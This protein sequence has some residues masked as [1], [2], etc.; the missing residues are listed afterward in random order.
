M[1][2]EG[3][4]A[5]FRCVLRWAEQY[6]KLRVLADIVTPAD[7]YKN[8]DFGSDGVGMLRLDDLLVIGQKREAMLD[9]LIGMF[10]SGFVNVFGSLH[11][12]MRHVWPVFYL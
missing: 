12:V 8:M 1:V 10:M 7:S 6:K 9:Y 4:N 3:V 11:P 5:A 2:E